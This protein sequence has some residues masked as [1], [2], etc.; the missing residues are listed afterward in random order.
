M[1]RVDVNDAGDISFNCVVQPIVDSQIV[2]GNLA[3]NFVFPLSSTNCIFLK[4]VQDCTDQF[5]VIM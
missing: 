5:S 1:L 4:V 2:K 3:M